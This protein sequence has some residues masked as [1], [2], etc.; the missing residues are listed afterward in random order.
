MTSSAL[1][2]CVSDLTFGA[3]ASLS[4]GEDSA[5]KGVLGLGKVSSSADATNTNFVYE[6]AMQNYQQPVISLSMGFET[7]NTYLTLGTDGS[8]I[9]YFGTGV[10]SGSTWDISVSEFQVNSVAATNSA[11][12]SAILDSTAPYL[13]VPST[14]FTELNPS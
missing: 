10:S 3:V 13:G 9:T 6:W 14:L 12:G 5:Y 1:S 7:S 11:S 4:F 2:S 8:A